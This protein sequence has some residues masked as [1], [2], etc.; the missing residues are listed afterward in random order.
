MCAD[1]ER[2]VRRSWEE[3]G[4]GSVGGGWVWEAVAIMMAVLRRG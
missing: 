1:E 4:C 2:V 3:D